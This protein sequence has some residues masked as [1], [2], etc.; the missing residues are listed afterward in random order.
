MD[1]EEVKIIRKL[2]N[3]TQ[4][5]FAKELGYSKCYIG[6]VEQ[7]LRPVTV[8]L[9]KRIVDKYNFNVADLQAYK[10]ITNQFIKEK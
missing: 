10:L 5:Q 1:K 4:Y 2:L 7:G 8:K 3:K 9:K 6:Y